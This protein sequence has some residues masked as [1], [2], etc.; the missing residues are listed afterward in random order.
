MWYSSKKLNYWLSSEECCSLEISMLLEK[1][2][3][4]WVKEKFK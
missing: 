1:E 2:T 3:T 4:H